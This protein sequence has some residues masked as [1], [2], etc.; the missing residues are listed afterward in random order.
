MGAHLWRSTSTV[1]GH[2]MAPGLVWLPHSWYRGRMCQAGDRA[3]GIPRVPVFGW[4]QTCLRQLHPRSTARWQCPRRTPAP[5]SH[6]DPMPTPHQSTRARPQPQGPLWPQCIPAGI[7]HRLLAAP[8]W[9]SPANPFLI[10]PTQCWADLGC[11][12]DGAAVCTPV[13]D[14][15]WGAVIACLFCEDRAMGVH[16]EPLGWR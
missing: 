12:G 9:C 15:L 14:H 7:R 1:L 10:V 5:G 16:G 13:P 11:P 6:P 2:G 8:C 3:H 4:Q